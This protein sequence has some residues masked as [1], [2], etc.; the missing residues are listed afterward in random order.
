MAHFKVRL[1]VFSWTGSATGVPR[2]YAP[3][4]I[5]PCAA[6]MHMA[7]VPSATHLDSS[8]PQHSTTW[9]VFRE[10]RAEWADRIALQAVCLIGCELVTD[11]DAF[12][13]VVNEVKSSGGILGMV[14]LPHARPYGPSPNSAADGAR[15]TGLDLD[16]HVDETLD[17]SAETLRAVAEAVVLDPV[18]RARDCGALLFLVHAE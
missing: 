4:W 11:T 5:L 7:H 14:H 8:P 6:P 1:T 9:A 2:T 13:S 16:L 17:P 12:A 10:M 3:E 15:K 18:R